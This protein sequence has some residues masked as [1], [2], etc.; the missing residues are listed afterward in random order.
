MTP[1]KLD[2]VEA[3]KAALPKATPGPWEI[4]LGDT[5][6]VDFLKG[7]AVVSAPEDEVFYDATVIAAAPVLVERVME[8]EATEKERDELLQ[9]CSAMRDHQRIRG[10]KRGNR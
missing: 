7:R 2:Q 1:E 5:V 3:A 9:R 4:R 8:L 10:N 6:S